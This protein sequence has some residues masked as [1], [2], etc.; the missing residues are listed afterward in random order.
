MFSCIDCMLLR[1]RHPR[2]N[3]GISSRFDLGTTLDKGVTEDGYVSGAA[4][5]V[6][7]GSLRETPWRNFISYIMIRVSIGVVH[8]FVTSGAFKILLI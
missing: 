7:S 5:D 2:V 4:N 8:D 1:V 3:P 6:T